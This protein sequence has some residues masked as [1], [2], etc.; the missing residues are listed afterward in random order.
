MGW[1]EWGE[2][3]NG[4]EEGTGTEGKGRRRA[5]KKREGKREREGKVSHQY[6]FFPA[7]SRKCKRAPSV[8]VTNR[9][10]LTYFQYIEPVFHC[11]NSIR[12]STAEDVVT[13]AK[14]VVKLVLMC[15]YVSL[16]LLHTQT[17]THE[18]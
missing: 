5:G 13:M 17:T 16:Q 6:F 1:E 14:A 9:Y 7:S 2:D 12:V 4:R 10:S 11:R 8:N 3:G 18:H 15:L